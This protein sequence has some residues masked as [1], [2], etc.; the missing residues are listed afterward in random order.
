MVMIV[1]K[2]PCKMQHE[3]ANI[4]SM[5]VSKLKLP[6]HELTGNHNFAFFPWRFVSKL[7]FSWCQ[8]T[9][10]VFN[11]SQFSRN[12]KWEGNFTWQDSQI[13]GWRVSSCMHTTLLTFQDIIT[14]SLLA[15]G[16][17][18]SRSSVNFAI[19]TPHHHLMISQFT[20]KIPNSLY[21]A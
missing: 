15:F 6:F 20:L 5:Y 18:T 8:K 4:C 10:L 14:Y 11:L 16:S 19:V 1:P 7:L 17:Q 12:S 3:K 21:C 13:W 2:N 9:L